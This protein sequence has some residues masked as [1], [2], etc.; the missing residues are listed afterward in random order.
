MNPSPL[1]PRLASIHPANI[2][3]LR[4]LRGVNAL[5]A[6]IIA[7]ACGAVGIVL[8]RTLFAPATGPVTVGWGFAILFCLGIA[9]AS[10]A[11]RRA[12]IFTTMVQAP[13]I[14][15]FEV[16]LAFKLIAGE[17]TIFA[18]SKIIT[19]FPIMAVATAIGLLLGT[20]RIIAQPLDR[21]PR[22]EIV[23]EFDE[24]PLTQSPGYF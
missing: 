2:A 4:S 11:V 21:R 14:L 16:F 6:I 7:V 20:V 24:A 15:T 1:R 17:G 22:T 23:E 18:A 8:D 19:A 5:A 10:L 13:I 3:V 9:L 12:S